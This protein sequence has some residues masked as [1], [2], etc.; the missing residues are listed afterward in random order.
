MMEDTPQKIINENFETIRAASKKR[1]AHPIEF[2]LEQLQKLD[3]MI[4]TYEEQ[5]YEAK[6]I[7]LE[8]GKLSSYATAVFNCQAGK[9]NQKSGTPL[10]ILNLG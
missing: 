4:T 8:M 3:N 7:D 9:S 10:P 5:I 2:R 1:R 6:R